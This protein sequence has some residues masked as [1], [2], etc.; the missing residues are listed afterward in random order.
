MHRMIWLL[1]GLTLMTALASQAAAPSSEDVAVVLQRQTQELLDA[2]APGTKAVWE[3]YLGPQATYTTEEGTVQTRAELVD[4]I[5]PMPKAVSG[6]IK[7]IDFKATVHDSVAITT[8][9]ADEHENYHGHAL[10]CQYRS[11]DTW[12]RTPAGWRLIGGQIMA[13]RTDPPAIQLTKQQ[14][15]EYIGRYT[16]TPE[17]SY[18]IRRAA[19]G[20]EGQQTGHK[21]ESLRAEVAD[22][23]FVPGKTRYRK[24]FQR[25]PDGHI[26]GFADRREAW[27][28][29]W[30]RV[31]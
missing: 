11:T 4:Q 25:G 16:L 26:T 3:R 21:V 22:V 18:E 7:V 12:L 13:L 15:E 5:Q 6:N 10:H 20:L 2:I 30:T 8:Y 14:L 29:I 31:P 23:L 17:I 24:V 9:V 28:L 19:D 27:D 1:A